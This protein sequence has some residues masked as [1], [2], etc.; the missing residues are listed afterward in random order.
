MYRTAT[1]PFVIPSE[2][3]RGPAAHPRDERRLGPATALYRTATLPFVIPAGAS[4]GP[5]AHPRDEERLGPATA[6]YRTA[7]LRFVIP[8]GASRGPAAHPR[9]RTPRSS[10]RFVSNRKP[11]P[12]SS[13]PEQVVGLRPTLG[14]KN[15]SVQQP[16]CIEPQP[17][18]LSSRA[19]QVVGLRPTLGTK[20]PP[21]SNRFY[22]TATLPFV[23]PSEAEGSA[24]PRTS[25]GNAEHYPQTELSS[26]PE[27]T[28]IS[29]HAA[30]DRAARAPFSKGKAH[31][32]HQ[33]HQ[34]R[35]EI[36]GSA[37]ERSAVFRNPSWVPSGFVSGHGFSRAE[38]AANNEGFSPC[39]SSV[40]VRKVN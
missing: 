35:Q 23:I 24:V 2:A 7:T 27:R 9:R 34:V 11:S 22:R 38:K 1:L 15:A 26:R 36:R 33:R 10:N 19:K 30:P 25:R 32:V 18:P 13:R 14:T 40:R 37:V 12:L 17:F 21:S 5:A 31:E 4:R 20:D 39:A 3:S 8:T 6:L 16:L 29:C 28:R